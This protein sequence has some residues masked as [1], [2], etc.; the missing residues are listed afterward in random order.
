MPGNLNFVQENRISN[1]KASRLPNAQYDF[2][3]ICL[4]SWCLDIMFF[5]TYCQVT[6]PDKYWSFSSHCSIPTGKLLYM[7]IPL[8]VWQFCSLLFKLLES[9]YRSETKAS[10]TCCAAKVRR[11]R[12]LDKLGTKYCSTVRSNYL[13]CIFCHL[14]KAFD[15]FDDEY[16]CYLN[17]LSSNSKLLEVGRLRG[18]YNLWNAAVCITGTMQFSINKISFHFMG[19]TN[20]QCSN[21]LMPLWIVIVIITV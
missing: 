21:I 13:L 15:S 16:I 9:T 6:G 4:Y 18:M 2:A 11:P 17:T 10:T 12:Q 3:I 20:S 7:Y 14:Y 8:T 19:E 5:C 1:Q